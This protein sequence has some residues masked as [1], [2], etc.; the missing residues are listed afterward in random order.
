MLCYNYYYYGDPLTNYF[1][2]RPVP[3]DYESDSK[4]SFFKFDS[5]RFDWINFYSIGLLPDILRNLIFTWFFPTIEDSLRTN[6]FG[7][8]S[9][10]IL[11]STLLISLY[12]KEKR[13]EVIVI[14]TFILGI[15]FF[16]SAGYLHSTNLN[17]EDFQPST[18]TRDRYMIPALPLYLMIFS[19]FIYLIWRVF[20]CKQLIKRQKTFY[21]DFKKGTLYIVA[22]FIF[23]NLFHSTPVQ[24][25]FD[26]GINFNN[27]AWFIQR[28][29]LD[30]EGL[31]KQNSI[32]LDGKRRAV[33][34]DAIPFFPYWG[35]W[36]KLLYE[37][38]IQFLP[39]EP[40]IKLKK[41]MSE[42][43]DVYAFR[44]RKWDVDSKYFRYLAENHGLI[45][46]HYSKTF[47]KF[48]QI[49]N[50]NV[51]NHTNLEFDQDCY[52]EENV[53]T[54]ISMPVLQD[55]NQYITKQFSLI[56]PINTFFNKN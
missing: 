22:A 53:N 47:C 15:L 27:P 12:Y 24:G 55:E 49:S 48:E 20:I 40:I 38:N 43:Y 39:Q 11:I 5:S 14:L 36:Q 46:K 19:L 37:Y 3:Q 44:D 50:A 32:I 8:I 26:T 29:P 9:F 25:A 31:S 6:P 54:I 28:F 21:Q 33:E 34:Y 4:M 2:E 52:N 56:A 10:V 41:L 7:V 42:G 23:I 18:G 1:D 16:Y 45:L 17:F 35:Y 30:S 13:T 51:S